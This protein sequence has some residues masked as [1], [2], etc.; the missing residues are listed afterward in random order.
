MIKRYTRKELS[1]IWNEKTKYESWLQVELYAIEAY[2]KVNKQIDKIDLQNLWKK[3]KIDIKRIEEIEKETKHDVIAFVNQISETLGKEKKWFHYG[4]TSTDVVDTALSLQIKKVNNVLENDLQKT[5]KILKSLAIK[6]KNTYQIGRTHGIHA[7]VTTFG[8][9][10]A[11][12]YDE[13]T[14]NLERFLQARKQIEVAKISGAVGN[15]ANVPLSIQD[16]VAKKLGLSSSK[17]S[18]QTLQRDRHAN[19]VFVLALIATSL[20]K[21]A[22]EIRNLQRTEINE[23]QE[24]FAKQQKGS[25]AMPHKKNPISCENISGLSR[26][27]R[28][29]VVSS[30]ENIP[31][32]HERDISHSSNERIILSDSTTLLNYM[33]NRFN[34]V[35]QNLVINKKQML[36]NIHLTKGVVFSQRI[37]L[38]IIKQKKW[39]RQK[40]YEFTQKMVQEARHKE[41]NLKDI[42]IKEKVLSE[43]V[44]EKVFELNYYS[45]N[46]DKVFKRLKLL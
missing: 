35:L 46:I 34:N 33:L 15:Y 37:M 7:E 11:L 45:Q 29:F 30:L 2:S 23:V 1:T 25:S 6:H 24:G 4:L 42:L 8:Y 17:I 16:Y 38:E 39:T 22:T 14:R 32:W 13:M 20:D 9:K 41:K 12:W 26:L 27:M 36:A 3:S 10:I 19:Y 31:L 5:L 40:A 21:F 44:V 28:G 18:S 43:E